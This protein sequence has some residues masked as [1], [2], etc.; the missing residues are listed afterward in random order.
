MT[1]SADAIRVAPVTFLLMLVE[2]WRIVMGTPFICAVV[3]IAISY[4]VKPVFTATTSFMPE[5]QTQLPAGIA[6]L[7]G[8]AGQFGLNLGGD[9]NESPQFYANLAESQTLVVDLLHESFVDPLAPADS[10]PLID[11]LDISFADSA[12][13]LER[14]IHELRSMIT[15]SVNRQTNVVSLS[16]SSHYAELSAAIANRIVSHINDFNLGQRRSR[17]AAKSRFVQQRL[18]H[19]RGDLRG[20]EEHVRSF[21]ERNHLF[22]SS[23]ELRF[24]YDRL[25][26]DV[27]IK[28]EVFMTLSRE[29]ET[30]AIQEVNNTPVITIVDMATPP[31]SRSS[32]RRT[33][34]AVV[35]MLLG[36]G[37]G[38]VLASLAAY[39]ENLGR[40][41]NPELRLLLA[42]LSNIARFGRRT[43][44]SKVDG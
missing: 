8:I 11:L 30:A 1:T 19:A 6:G 18:Q 36:G 39:F 5:S 24:E 27:S 4:V 26:R 41:A 23:P 14:S 31:A 42:R 44:G 17:A 9:A 15:T 29:A 3:V 35:A 16:V 20:A 21:L 7:A 34:S 12:L 38:L 43:S 33:R 13:R 22:E 2:H 32:P 25:Q 10:S 28:H 40:E 37:L